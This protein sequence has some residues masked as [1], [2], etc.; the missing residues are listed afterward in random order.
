MKLLLSAMLARPVMLNAVKVSLVVGTCLNLINRGGAIW[1]G[2]EIEWGKFILN[3]VV[4]YLV[5]SYS[6]AKATMNREH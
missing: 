4:P 2:G 5:A 6:G 1:R 3:F